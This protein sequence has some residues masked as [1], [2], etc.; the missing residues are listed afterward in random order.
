MQVCRK[1]SMEWRGQRGPVVPLHGKGPKYFETTT[2]SYGMSETEPWYGPHSG[3]HKGLRFKLNAGGGAKSG[4]KSHIDITLESLVM[5][6]YLAR[7]GGGL[8]RH[9][10]RLCS[11]AWLDVLPY[12]WLVSVNIAVIN[13]TRKWNQYFN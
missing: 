9:A 3:L 7:F 1:R 4:R 6:N 8:I 13:S 2:E 12:F 11:G 10:P 5:G